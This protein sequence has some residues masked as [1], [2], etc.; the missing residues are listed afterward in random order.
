MTRHFLRKKKFWIRLTVLVFAVPILLL[1]IALGILYLEQ[2]DLIQSEINAL[3]KGHKGKISIGETH[4]EPFANFPYISIKVDN[5]R[6]LESKDST[7][8]VL[9]DVK[10]I[11][12]GF[13]VW[14]ILQG[15]YDIKNILIED[16]LLNLIFHKDG[17]LNIQN[18]LQTTQ[19]S[20]GGSPMDIHLK[21]IQLRN[22]LPRELISNPS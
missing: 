17:T 16:G 7:A 13:N 2:D 19:E 6:I 12:T 5:V 4:L 14:D 3:N 15:N 10:D 21:N 11:Y 1:T 9:L 8:E 18:A 20:E 22:I